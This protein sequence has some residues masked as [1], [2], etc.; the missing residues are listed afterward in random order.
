MSW[1]DCQNNLF[2]RKREINY[3]SLLIYRIVLQ[4]KVEVMISRIV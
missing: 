1:D 3:L 2:H 4:I